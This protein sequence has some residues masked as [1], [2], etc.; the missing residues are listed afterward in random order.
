LGEV[1]VEVVG[2]VVIPKVVEVEVVVQ[3]HGVYI[4]LRVCLLRSLL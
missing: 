2:Q 3:W 4:L 1:L